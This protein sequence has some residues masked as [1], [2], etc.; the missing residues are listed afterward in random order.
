LDGNYIGKLINARE[1]GLF[2]YK[3]LMDV[4]GEESEEGAK[5]IAVTVEYE[6]NGKTERATFK[7]ESSP[8]LEKR[9]KAVYGE[10]ARI[11]ASKVFTNNNAL[12]KKRSSRLCISS[13]YAGIA[14]NETILESSNLLRSTLNPKLEEYERVMKESGLSGS[15]RMDLV[16]GEEYDGVKEKLLKKGIMKEEKGELA[17]DKS[18]VE[19]LMLKK[20]IM[21]EA[22]VKKAETMLAFD[23][24]KFFLLLPKRERETSNAFFGIEGDVSEKQLAL[25]NILSDSHFKIENASAIVSKKFEIEKLGHNV[26]GKLAGIALFYLASDKTA[27]WCTENFECSEEELKRGAEILAPHVD[28]REGKLEKLGIKKA[29]KRAQ[30]FVGLIK[31]AG[32]KGNEKE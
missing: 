2:A 13:A 6:K 17:L 1:C 8:N 5:G 26:P 20:R 11:V 32:A 19:S 22:C 27:E 10:D 3:R 25:L 18:V 16:E 30:K 12:I 31:D 7:L 28:A 21:R 14:S 9:V 15:V 29:G 4:L 23:L 24:L